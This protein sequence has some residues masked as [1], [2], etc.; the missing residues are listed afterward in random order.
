MHGNSHMT[1]LLLLLWRSW[2]GPCFA[3]SCCA[4]RR[5][6]RFL[7]SLRLIISSVDLWVLSLSSVLFFCSVVCNIV[8]LLLPICFIVKRIRLLLLCVYVILVIRRVF[9]R[10]RGVFFLPIGSVPLVASC[11]CVVSFKLAIQMNGFLITS[12]IVRVRVDFALC[13][14]TSRVG[15]CGVLFRIVLRVLRIRRRCERFICHISIPRWR[16]FNPIIYV[17]HSSTAR[18]RERVATCRFLLHV[19]VKRY[20]SQRMVYPRR[21][22]N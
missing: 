11:C 18:E 14:V 19:A 6:T 15:V 8:L 5:M 3:C 16:L 2:S 22:F 20:P 9:F 7:Y 12:G 13:A 1:S 17:D 10:V 4:L 21:H